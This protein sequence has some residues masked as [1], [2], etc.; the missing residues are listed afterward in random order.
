M[1]EVDPVEVIVLPMSCSAW[2][3]EEVVSSEV[4]RALVCMA[5]CTPE[6]VAS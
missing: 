1:P 6:I 5:C 4:Q 2:E 3:M